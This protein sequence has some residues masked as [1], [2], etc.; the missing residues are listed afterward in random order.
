MNTKTLTLLTALSMT[1]AANAKA[2]DQMSVIGGRYDH[3][4]NIRNAPS[5]NSAVTATLWATG[6]YGSTA[7]RLTWCGQASREGNTTWYL[8]SFTTASHGEQSGWVAGGMIE[9]YWTSGTPATAPSGGGSAGAAA[10]SSS[11]NTN[12]NQNVINNYVVVPRQ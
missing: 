4:A 6:Y 2:C 3:Q 7:G 8:V 12:Q 9:T 1:G 10:A 11:E 5:F